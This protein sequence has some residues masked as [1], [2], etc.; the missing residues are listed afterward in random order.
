M[1]QIEKLLIRGIRSFDPAGTNIIEFYTPLTIIV[2]HNGAGK[3]T[4]IECLKYATTGDL[5]PNSRNGAFIHDPKLAQENEVKAQI[6]LRFRNVNGRE[7]V[8][9]RSLSLTQKKTAMTMKTI[10][11][12]LQVHDPETDKVGTTSMIMAGIGM[13]LLLTAPLFVNKQKSSLST[14]CAELD[15]ELP[16]QLGVS[17]AILE[18]VIFCHQEESFWPLAEPSTLKKKFDEIFASTRYT[19]A[20]ENIKTLRK[21]QTSG[22]KV[23]QVNVERYKQD[24]EK[25]RKIRDNME[26][27]QERIQIASNRISE[28]D[29]PEGEVQIV[30]L[31]MQNLMDQKE[32]M[33]ALEASIKQSQ[34]ELDMVR[35]NMDDL[36]GTLQEYRGMVPSESSPI[37]A[38]GIER[39][40]IHIESDAELESMLQEYLANMQESVIEQQNL[41]RQCRDLK[42]ESDQL[43]R[44]YTNEAE[45]KGRLHAEKQ[46]H[47]R[48]VEERQAIVVQLS[49]KHGYVGFNATPLSASDIKRFTKRLQGEIDTR[50]AGIESFKAKA[51]EREGAIISKKGELQKSLTSAEE[52]KRMSRTQMEEKRR[53]MSQLTNRLQELHVS[54]VEID[55]QKAK[56][57]EEEAILEEREASLNTANFD[58]KANSL[59]REL[60]QKEAEIIG[61]N[62]EIANLNRQADSR[63][64]L[65]LKKS[66][67]RRKEDAWNQLI[68]SSKQDFEQHLRHMPAIHE[69]EKKTETYLREKQRAVKAGEERQEKENRQLSAVE[70]KLSMA[71]TSLGKKSKELNDKLARIKQVTNDQDYAAA[72]DSVESE[73]VQLR[74]QMSSMDSATSMY[75]RFIKKYKET[76]SCPL[77]FRGFE[78]DDGQAFLDRLENIL[79][80]VPDAR[81][82]TAEEIG[83]T[84]AKRDQLRG[85]QS[86]NDDADRLK[87]VEI[88]E[89]N[90][91]IE[92]YEGDRA[93]VMSGLED[94]VCRDYS[95]FILTD[96]ASSRVELQTAQTLHE[97]A[98]QIVK[99]KREVD[100]VTQDVER[101]NRSLSKTGSTKT[102]DVA[103]EE[104]E[105]LHEGCQSIRKELER[106]NR[107][108]WN[109]QQEVQ[110]RHNR[111]RDHRERLQEL[112]A[113]LTERERLQV[114]MTELK[115]EIEKSQQGAE[116][117]DR[118][119]NEL[120]PQVEQVDRELFEYRAQMTA[121]ETGYMK[122]VDL[123]RQS[124]T[125]FESFD[126]EIERYIRENKE[127]QYRRCNDAIDNYDRQIKQRKNEIESI[128]KQIENVK[129]QITD[130]DNIK[131][132][133]YDNLKYR[134]LKREGEQLEDRIATVRV[135]VGRYDLGSLQTQH[136]RVKKKHEDL[137]S[138]R[139]GLIGELKQMQQ[140]CKS[141]ERDLRTDYKDV[142]E[143]YRDHLIALKTEEMANLDLEK[144]AK[145]L[146]TAIM[147]YHSKKMEDINKIIRELW[148]NTYQGSDI[149]TIEI[150]SDNDGIKGNRQYNYRVVMLKGETALDMR[151]RCSAGQ[152]VLTSLII[153]LALAETFCINCGILA[154]DEPTTNLDRD[155]IESL[156]ESLANIIKLRRQQS[157]FQLIIITHD[158]EFMQLLGKSEFADYYWRVAKDEG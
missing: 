157:N 128:S 22:L 144:Y 39:M 132:Q 23:H 12:L 27:L 29:G 61:V 147:T 5:P 31:D 93:I 56:I 146:D 111:I 95:A 41:D 36:R 113:T 28:L 135:E 134:K 3:T 77:C 7:M 140:Q 158:E 64:E 4:V 115:S 102:L 122:E 52:K 49:Q 81:R 44:K 20:L 88:P 71:R 38:H 50:V 79:H 106:L 14:R 118:L 92:E 19:K 131:R 116:A 114:S 13:R 85:L 112:Q 98:Q 94:V 24:Q 53:K 109:R 156:A 65:T 149:D 130:A 142:D 127:E 110:T 97:R 123:Y 126:K 54:Q 51:R 62:E 96:L 139:A 119:M 6:K 137:V 82:R 100:V 55:E 35:R 87:N 124:M 78:H 91:R 105:K 154:L 45:L 104:L 58:A 73:V 34:N 70:T 26:V 99:M 40:S 15:A 83:E 59:N 148:V 117:A 57:Q 143:Q 120:K 153:R 21:D 121:E 108:R 145:A 76:D 60:Q 129:T 68:S 16:L 1:S 10:E 9:T 101:L 69:M 89:L 32:E 84:E 150:R 2:G 107:E 133:I 18:N 25:A 30:L 8:V 42:V 63:A 75:S 86:V 151:G 138:E 125:Q 74:D 103:Q 155:N 46:A 80:K 141:L 43:Q 90:A 67:M 152:K 136:Q 72:L 33:Q 66:D 47:D 17:K 11:S 37:G 48:M